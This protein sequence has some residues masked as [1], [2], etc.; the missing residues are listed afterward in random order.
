MRTST[1]TLTIIAGLSVGCSSTGGGP[2]SGTGRPDDVEAPFTNGVST[3]SGTATAGYVDGARK[4]ARFS[5]PVNVA[6]RDGIVYVADFD[7]GK[8]RAID[9]DTHVTRTLIAQ[10]SF[11]RPFGMAFSRNGMLYVSTDNDQSGNHTSMS[12]SIWKVDVD[13][14]NAGVLAN[15]IGR[16]RG[17]AVLP[18]GRIA[19]ADYLH[20]VIELID[21]RS[22]AVTTIAGAWDAK[23]MIDGAG[24]VARF[25]S[26]YSL[27]VRADGKLIVTDSGNNRIR[28]VGL[29]GVTSTLS[30]ASAP[31]FVDG[32]MAAARFSHPQ[33]IVVA[34]TGAVFITD[35]G[36]FRVRRIAGDRVDTI[37]G[38]GTGGHVDSDDPLASEIYGLEGL[39]VTPDG[40]MVYVAD[41]NRGDNVPYNR[42]RQ[43]ELD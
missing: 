3:L 4:N 16:P 20:Q 15:G 21:P 25:S 28:L 31:G 19:A 9:A 39:A 24:A 1:L 6:Y 2:D 18:D 32:A 11:R 7:N 36:N 35:P 37:A 10:Q 12:G 42:I 23:G 43:I 29:D 14:G 30:G 27:A 5:N 34:A 33:G 8:L 13:N 26:P 40:T 38:D 41:G 17:L 22:G